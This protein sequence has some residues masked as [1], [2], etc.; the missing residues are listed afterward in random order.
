MAFNLTK[1]VDKYITVHSEGYSGEPV[2][3]HN[4]TTNV[5]IGE[6]INIGSK[7]STVSFGP[8]L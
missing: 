4:G 6:T 3:L 5:S 1:I 2:L 8:R 7:Y